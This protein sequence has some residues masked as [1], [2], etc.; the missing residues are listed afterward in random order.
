M[1]SQRKEEVRDRKRD[2]KMFALALKMEAGV[3]GQ[4]M[5]V[6]PKR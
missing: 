4:S 3:M 2:L 5:R 1:K 6:V